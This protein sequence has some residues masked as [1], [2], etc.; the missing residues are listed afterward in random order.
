[1]CKFVSCYIV[2]NLRLYTIG[3]KG[4]YPGS[5]L[6]PVPCE[7]AYRFYKLNNNDDADLFSDVYV[8]NVFRFKQVYLVSIAPSI[9]KFNSFSTD[10][11]FW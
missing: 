6:D 7:G 11:R 4:M 1:M 8:Y 3:V 10:F 5:L 9:V 2:Y